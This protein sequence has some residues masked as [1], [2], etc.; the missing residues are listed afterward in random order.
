MEFYSFPGEISA[1][2]GLCTLNRT[3]VRGPEGIWR[4]RGRRG[5]RDPC[6]FQGL[7]LGI[8]ADEATN[9]IRFASCPEANLCIAFF[10][11]FARIA[12]EFMVLAL[13]LDEDNLLLLT[14][15]NVLHSE[16]SD[17]LVLNVSSRIY[18]LLA[19]RQ[20]S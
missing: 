16:E 18:W 17:V 3:R 10:W 11:K 12:V 14:R 6:H 4:E 20:F 13:A 19:L 15:T 8:R 2:V 5:S 9:T 7:R 1:K